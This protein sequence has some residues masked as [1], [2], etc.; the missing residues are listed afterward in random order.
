VEY[1]VREDILMEMDDV[2]HIDLV[3]E[4][5][6]EQAYQLI[7]S[8]VLDQPEPEKQE[9]VFLVDRSVLLHLKEAE[10]GGFEYAVFDR[11]SK[12]KTAEGKIHSDAVMDRID[13]THDY[14]K[15]ARDA[16]I[17]EADLDSIKV[18]QVGLT[19]LKEFRESDIRCREIWEPE[20]LPKCQATIKVDK[21]DGRL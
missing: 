14:L 11:Q 19:S 2:G 8:G 15:A 21:K 12:Q 1:S 17:E 13:P 6:E 5:I 7:Q 3:R 18:A 16:A 20:K 10:G 4:S 9:G